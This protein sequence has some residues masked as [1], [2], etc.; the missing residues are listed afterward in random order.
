MEDLRINL[1]RNSCTGIREGA[2]G[3][4]EL[5]LEVLLRRGFTGLT[6]LHVLNCPLRQH[7]LEYMVTT[8]GTMIVLLLQ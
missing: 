6:M 5:S 8:N 1:V 3:T 4:L 2:G 7:Q